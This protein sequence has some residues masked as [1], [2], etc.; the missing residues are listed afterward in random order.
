MRLW[1][2][3]PAPLDWLLVPR[4]PCDG[5]ESRAGEVNVSR[6]AI[7]FWANINHFSIDGLSGGSL[8]LDTLAT[9]APCLLE[10][11][12]V[13]GSIVRLVFLWQALWI[14]STCISTSSVHLTSSGIRCSN[15]T[16]VTGH[17]RDEQRVENT[18][19]KC[20]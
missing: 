20:E 3:G 4:V 17:N 7:P 14:E 8:D 13:H 5:L 9:W 11:T 6:L 2:A 12:F 16:P 10:V 19:D 1:A 15:A 18:E